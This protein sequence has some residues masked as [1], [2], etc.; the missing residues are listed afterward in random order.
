MLKDSFIETT[1]RTCTRCG[2][3]AWL[4]NIEKIEQLRDLS[5]RVKS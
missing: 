5:P 4:G 2:T 1:A 3:I